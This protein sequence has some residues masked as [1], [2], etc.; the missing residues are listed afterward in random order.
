MSDFLFKGK[1]A[2]LDFLNTGNPGI[3]KVYD[4]E[5]SANNPKSDI[6]LAMVQY[7]VK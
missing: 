1:E 6:R 5:T 4:A 7:L 3:V 2:N